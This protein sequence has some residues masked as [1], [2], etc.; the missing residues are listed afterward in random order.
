[1]KVMGLQIQRV[2]IC[3]QTRKP[4][5]NSRTILLSNSDIDFHTALLWQ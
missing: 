4:I 5:C 2:G 3:E 1:M